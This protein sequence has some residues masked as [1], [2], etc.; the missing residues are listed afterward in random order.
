MIRR[1]SARAVMARLLRSTRRL[2]PDHTVPVD[3][4]RSGVTSERWASAWK[5][6][7]ACRTVCGRERVQ[8]AS[9]VMSG[10]MAIRGGRRVAQGRF[11]DPVTLDPGADPPRQYW[12]MTGRPIA[13]PLPLGI[14]HRALSVEADGRRRSQCRPPPGPALRLPSARGR[15]VVPMLPSQCAYH[16][17]PDRRAVVRRCAPS[18]RST[19]L[20]P[21]G[22]GPAAHGHGSR[23]DRPGH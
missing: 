19:R 8:G 4:R 1:S 9:R 16:R 22:S 14:A 11:D 10:D 7:G 17:G 2:M 3:P 13:S 21:A 20:R 6:D 15:G 23:R 5:V 18:S 12:R